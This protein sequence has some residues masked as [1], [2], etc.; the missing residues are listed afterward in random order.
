[1][2]D[3][4]CHMLPAVDDGA[5]SE[6][7]SLAMARVAVQSG[8]T[9]I[10]LTPH[11]NAPDDSVGFSALELK[12]RMQQLQRL[13]QQA[14][15]PLRLHTGMEL[16]ATPDLAA[17]LDAGSLLTLGGSHY[18]LVEFAFGEAPRF[19]DSTLRLLRS[20][21]FRP[22]LAHPERYYC[23]QDEPELLL[24]WA[25]GGIALQLNK[26]SFF[27]MFGN[28]AART[29]KWCMQRGCLHLIGSDAH[30]PYRRTPRLSDIYDLVSDTSGP[31][32]ADFLLQEN[33]AAILADRPVQPV[34]AEF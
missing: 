12:R 11:F 29:A 28:H 24:R 4:H 8:V 15:L 34:M 13:F 16:F 18:L 7:E 31:E 25:R 14:E 17:L 20:R 22:V 10:A 32:I 5:A 6:E 23:V 19:L 26:G 9:E 1:M 2:I 30:S 33:P 27:G 21:G 3:L